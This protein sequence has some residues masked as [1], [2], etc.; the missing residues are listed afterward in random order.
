MIFALMTFSGRGR[1]IGSSD[2]Q[3]SF[4]PSKPL[5]ARQLLPH[6]T[7]AVKE[8]AAAVKAAAA[9]QAA[10]AAAVSTAAAASQAAAAAAV[11]TAASQAAAAAVKVDPLFDQ[12]SKDWL[13]TFAEQVKSNTNLQKQLQ[14]IKDDPAQ[15]ASVVAMADVFEE[16][17]N[18]NPSLQ[19][20]LD[21]ITA[22]PRI[23]HE[24]DV[25]QSILG[26]VIPFRVF[27]NAHDAAMRMTVLADNAHDAADNAHD[28]AGPDDR[29]S[30]AEVSSVSAQ[31]P[32]VHAPMNAAR[33]LYNHPKQALLYTF[34]LS[35]LYAASDLPIEWGSSAGNLV[36]VGREPPSEHTVP[37]SPADPGDAAKGAP[38][39]TDASSSDKA[40][41]WSTLFNNKGEHDDTSSRSEFNQGIHEVPGTENLPPKPPSS[42]SP[43]DVQDVV[44]QATSTSSQE[45]IPNERTKA[46]EDDKL[47]GA[48]ATTK[49]FS[50]FKA[51][52]EQL[53][54]TPLF[55]AYAPYPDHPG[56][57]LYDVQCS[58]PEFSELADEIGTLQR[59]CAIQQCGCE[60]ETCGN[61]TWRHKPC[62]A[63]CK[64]E[65]I[66]QAKSIQELAPTTPMSN[67]GT[68]PVQ[69]DLIENPEQFTG[70][71][72]LID[73]KSARMIWESMY[74]DKVC[75]KPCPGENGADAS[76][77][78]RLVYQVVSGLQ[79]SVNT[80]IAMRYGVY[81]DTHEPANLENFKISRSMEFMPWRELYDK[82][83]GSFPDR[84]QNLHFVFEL[85]TRALHR[86]APHLEKLVQVGSSTCSKCESQHDRTLDLLHQLVKPP[87][88]AH[89]DCGAARQ[90]V[91]SAVQ[92]NMQ[93]D[94][95]MML[96]AEVKRRFQRMGNLMTCVGCDRCK[97]WG[98]LQFHGARVALGVLLSDDAADVAELSG[99][100][101]D[102]PRLSDLKPNDV[103]ALVNAL[104]QVSKSIDQV[105]KWSPDAT[106]AVCQAV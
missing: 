40:P 19:K 90:A 86:L 75:F 13:A 12:T 82:R 31:L 70:Y 50:D 88:Q 67:G 38:T 22:D 87:D 25:A 104:A 2:Q 45:L 105:N 56:E 34:I 33:W 78:K 102:V 83:V 66:K 91:D 54:T 74:T 3:M 80:H 29:T 28:A 58:I 21:S 64:D 101:F 20:E 6:E 97:L 23:Q 81:A 63:K 96:K 39:V 93:D 65:A 57:E 27:D 68:G 36:G 41:S 69:Y 24:V 99:S 79:A 95:A 8:A 42:R 76:P 98:S 100:Q 89:P 53:V 15:L 43:Q 17:L 60:S 11:M 92:F 14:S 49:A 106:A 47:K 30:L 5:K 16:A 10:A 52:L 46:D 9:S 48:Q 94:E 55:R 35:G 4:L 26:D 51:R 18:E 72:T 7:E 61:A 37:S 77:E 1:R 71:G 103:V 84:I 59:G 62:F 85:M 73:D 44:A 32:L